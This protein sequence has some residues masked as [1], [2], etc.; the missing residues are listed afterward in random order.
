MQGC[1][2]REYH[3]QCFASINSDEILS[4]HEDFTRGTR[5]YY[6]SPT[7]GSRSVTISISFWK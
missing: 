7:F 2:N 3:Q 5:K 1:S 6:D 4:G